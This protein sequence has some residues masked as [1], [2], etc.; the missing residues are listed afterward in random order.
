[1]RLIAIRRWLLLGR[2]EAADRALE[3]LKLP[4]SPPLLVVLRAF[5]AADIALRRLQPRAAREHL[6]RARDGAQQAGVPA[7]G[8]EVANALER[9]D[10]P[11]AWLQSGEKLRQLSL[12]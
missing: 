6:G 7:L 1:G 3:A 10:R 9:L 2:V 5:A 8:A 12:D 11:A 4:G